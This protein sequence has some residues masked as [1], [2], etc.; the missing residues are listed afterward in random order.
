[1]YFR[2]FGRHYHF[3]IC[4]PIVIFF[5]DRTVADIGNR[6]VLCCNDVV[7]SQCVSSYDAAS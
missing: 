7:R 6:Y 3:V 4:V 5:V 1:M 2:Q